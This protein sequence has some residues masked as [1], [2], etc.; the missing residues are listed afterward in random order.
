M[1]NRLLIYSVI[2]FAGIIFSCNDK[3]TQERTFMANVPVYMSHDDFNK[4]VKITEQQEIENAGKIYIKDNYL[5]LNDINKGIHVFDNTNPETPVYVCFINIPGN[6]DMAIKGNILYADS[7]VDLVELDITN[8]KEPFVIDRVENAFP[9]IYPVIDW[10]Y[11]MADVDPTK[12]VVVAWKVEQITTTETDYIRYNNMYLEYSLNI[13]GASTSNGTGNV[14]IAGSM[15]RFAIKGN[16][17]YAI[18]NGY[19]LKIFDIGTQ[20]IKK[21]DSISTFW[22]IETLFVYGDNLFIGSTNGMFIYDVKDTKHPTYISEYSHVTSCDPVVV[23]GN[24]AFVT[25]RSGNNCANTINELDI[26]SLE[27][28][29]EPI[30]LKSYEMYN[31]H[32]LGIDNDLLFI[33]DGDAG[34]KIYNISDVLNIDNNLIKTFPDIK[35]FD[36]IPYNNILIMSGQE[37]IIMYDYSDV[38]NI[39]E[40]SRIPVSGDK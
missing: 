35:T 11:P 29:K 8:P 13:D 3:V 6:V 21:S 18:N 38:N 4:A 17:L 37:G 20:E 28:I 12:G 15:A 32:G 16:A 9:N 24:Y 19:E 25:L 10:Y 5:F 22:N 27:N 39:V 34:L 33:C 7:Y 23:N 26:V 2:L 30:L 40:I 14:G 36:V 1:K 31:P